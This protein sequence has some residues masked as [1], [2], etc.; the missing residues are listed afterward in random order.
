MF[1]GLG[2]IRSSSFTLHS[3]GIGIIR[4]TGFFSILTGNY[5]SKAK[6]NRRSIQ[7]FQ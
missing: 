6:S 3:R 2:F 5:R 1:V 7:V 4:W